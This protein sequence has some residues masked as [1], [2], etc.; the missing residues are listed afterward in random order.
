MAQFQVYEDNSGEFRWRFLAD[1]E[2]IMATASEGYVSETGAHRALATFLE[3]V[4]R[5]EVIDVPAE[6]QP[7]PPVDANAEEEGTHVVQ[8]G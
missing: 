4:P 1:N 6:L 3:L 8:D 2:R 5:A 7:P